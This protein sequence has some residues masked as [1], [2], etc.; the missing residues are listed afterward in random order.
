MMSDLKN[1]LNLSRDALELLE[2]ALQTFC[3]L[4]AELLP[5]LLRYVVDGNDETVVADLVSAKQQQLKQRQQNLQSHIQAVQ[6]IAPVVH[7]SHVQTRNRLVDD[8]LNSFL[9]IVNIS[10]AGFFCRLS[11]VWCS[12][13]SGHIYAS[14][15]PVHPPPLKAQMPWF[16]QRVAPYSQTA[17]KPVCAVTADIIDAMY[18]EA[19]EPAGTFARE[20]YILASNNYPQQLLVNCGVNLNGFITYTL[21]HASIVLEALE[22]PQRDRRIHALQV[23]IKGEVPIAR[24]TEAIAN[25]AL[26][27]A[28]SERELA[29]KLLQQDPQAAVPVLQTKAE[30]GN[31]SERQQAVKLLWNLVGEEVRP[32]LE[33]RLVVEKAA[34]VRSAIEQLMVTPTE[35]IVEQTTLTSAPLQQVEFNV[36]VPES[37][38]DILEKIRDAFN[39]DRIQSCKS[40]FQYLKN[41]HNSSPQVNILAMNNLSKTT[42]DA[43]IELLDEIKTN[44]Q[45]DED[46]AQRQFSTIINQDDDQSNV[47]LSNLTKTLQEGTYADCCNYPHAPGYYHLNHLQENIKTLLTL[48]E[49]Q[50]IHVVRLLILMGRLVDKR[51]A[52]YSSFLLD[53]EGHELLLCY[54]QHHPECGDL[55]EL[56]AVLEC[57]HLSPDRIGDDILGA[58]GNSSFWRWGQE[59]IW[60]YFAERVYLLESVLSPNTGHNWES[61]YENR[62]RRQNGFKVL[63]TF[64]QPPAELMPVLWNLAFEG[65]KTER[66]IAQDC[67]NDF[68]G[69]QTRILTALFDPNRETRTI[70]ADWLGDRG[71]V[72][73]I[74]PL[75]QALKQEKSEA[76]KDTMLRSLEKLGA[77][78]DEFLDRKNLLKDSQT[79]LKKGI[80]GILS[81]FPFTAAPTIHWHDTGEMVEPHILKGLILQCFKQK[82]PEPG[83]ILRRY[84]ALWWADER[85]ALGQFVLQS[86]IA[87]DTAPAYSPEAA[88]RLAQ[89]QAQ[90][91]I[92]YYQQLQQRHPHTAGANYSTPTYDELYQQAYNRLTHE[93]I[94]SAIKE[95]GILAI[96]S[97]CCGGSAITP[98]N[99]YLKTW[100]GRRTAQC[101]TLLQV[102]VWIED[103]SAIQLLLSVAN[104][105]R[106]R[107]IQKEAEKLV[108]ELAERNGWSRDEL[109]DRTI[110]TSGFDQGV[111]QVLDYGRRQFTLLLD[112]DMSLVLK[113]PDGKVIKSLPAGRKDEDPDQVKLAKKQLSDAKKQLKQVL[114]MQRER[115]YEAMCTQRSWPFADWDRYLNQHPIIGRYCQQLVWAVYNGDAL[116]QTFR[117]LEDRSLTDAEDEDVTPAPTAT[118]RLA[119][120]C[121]L[122]PEQIEAWQTHF[123][124]Y[125]VTPLLGQFH[126]SAYVLPDAQRQDTE[127]NDFAGHLIAAFQLRGTASKRGYTR[128]SAGDGGWFSGYHKTFSGLGVEAV[129]SFSGNSLPEENRTVALTHLTFYQLPEETDSDYFYSRPKL[130]LGEVPGVLLSEI[131]NDLQTIAAQGSGYDPDWQKKVEY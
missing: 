60:P 102:L 4:D 118:V 98:I 103:N 100:Y 24:F 30:S 17:S 105:F 26:S 74:E 107:G 111:E 68:G 121:T 85:E 72:T 124:D 130:T 106:T 84:V 6:F 21:K 79:L 61:Q 46:E 104:R 12:L 36:P 55:R 15:S 10:D 56:A 94:G 65:P 77:S 95:K 42:A 88:D 50:L 18:V 23:L 28:K 117:P 22:Q 116:V 75:K 20:V 82:T 70:A 31:S 128:G 1:L 2:Q 78:V 131:W 90:Q 63:K 29:A 109:S 51:Y 37:A 40:F 64:P 119:H 125:D 45:L 62:K 11:Q 58:W 73:A 112:T 93:C 19:G 99:T 13:F 91:Q 87:Q 5:R 9:S 120:S 92:Q 101:K 44:P 122:S 83:P 39:Q 89:T 66:A 80:P 67:L 123:G 54:R 115:L 113:N 7:F 38:G 53:H 41:L 69:T 86:W 59:A 14:S 25:L 33:S 108:S 43:I 57:L 71:D 126:A 34:K 27:S 81:W 32:V 97:A 3:E 96:A 8:P 48:T 129:I 110:P 114:T 47:I 52:Q 49:F 16:L 76:A 35:G 127:L